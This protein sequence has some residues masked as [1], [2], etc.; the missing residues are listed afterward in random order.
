MRG[1]S[2]KWAKPSL[3]HVLI[4]KV[5]LGQSHTPLFLMSAAAFTLQLL[6]LVVVTE[7]IDIAK[8]LIFHRNK[9]VYYMAIY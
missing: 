5:L 8:D 6:T 4:N 9:N 1:Q 2:T 3:P 7:M